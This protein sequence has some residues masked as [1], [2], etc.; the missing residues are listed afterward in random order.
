PII[1]R[2]RWCRWC[3][4]SN[5]R[6]ESR[7]RRRPWCRNRERATARVA[8]FRCNLQRRHPWQDDLNLGALSRRGF[9]IDAAAQTVGDQRIDDMKAEPGAALVASGGEKRI[10]CAPAHLG[11]HAA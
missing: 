10:E 4:S 7:S 2:W 9:E 6:R 3:V 5:A 8:L 11:V 1:P